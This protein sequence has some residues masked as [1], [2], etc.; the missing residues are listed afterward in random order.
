MHHKQA[1]KVAAR[2]QKGPYGRDDVTSP[3]NEEK[4]RIPHFLTVTPIS[5]LAEFALMTKLMKTCPM[6]DI[7]ACLMD[8]AL[9]SRSDEQH[10]FVS[11]T[12]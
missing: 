9:P 3:L 7:G 8:G 5:R 10:Q 1:R 4:P 12:G 6:T 11:D 2:L